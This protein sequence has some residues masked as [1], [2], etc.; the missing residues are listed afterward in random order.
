M[1]NKVIKELKDYR[2][3]N[4]SRTRNSSGTAGSFL[5]SF[6]IIDGKKIY[7]KLS[8][9][10]QIDG[11]FGHEA[12]NEIIVDRFLTLIG[13]PHLEYTLH[14]GLISIDSKEYKTYFCSSTDFKKT[15]DSKT[16]I[17]LFYQINRKNGEDINSFLKRYGF[18]NQI[19]TMFVADYLI[20][21]R[22][23]HGANFE[24]LKN[25]ESIR[26]SPFFDHGLSLLFSCHNENEIKN[27]DVMDDKKIQ[28]FAGTDSVYKNLLSIPKNK[29]PKINVFNK[30]DIDYLFYNLDD[31]ISKNHQKKIFELLY[32]RY[33]VYEDLCN[34][35]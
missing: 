19:Y 24:V 7:Y 11:K 28:S 30:N 25:G 23:R 20:L 14:N 12:I 13:I 26:L 8:D 9:F 17:D 16:P 3:L 29:L 35:R 5:K 22:D 2:Y 6:E 1:D 31:L 10:S 21:N 32:K 27:F 33:K 34:K 4:W 15:G 18:I